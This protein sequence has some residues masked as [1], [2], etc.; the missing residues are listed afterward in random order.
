MAGAN[1]ALNTVSATL[2]TVSE[3]HPLWAEFC[4]QEARLWI[5]KARLVAKDAKQK[6]IANAS[7]TGAAQGGAA[8]TALPPMV[9]E[10]VSKA[11]KTARSYLQQGLTIFLN[12]Y[13]LLVFYFFVNN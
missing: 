6:A 3:E 1:Q 12:Y 2:K 5:H 8:P 11:L 10:A 7:A 4:W 9:A 13:Q